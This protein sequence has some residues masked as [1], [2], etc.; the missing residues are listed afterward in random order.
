MAVKPGPFDLN[1]TRLILGPDGRGTSKAVSPT[2]YEDL[3]RDFGDFA[4]HVLI[5]QFEFSE[6]WPTWEVHPEGDEFVYLIRGD[7]DLVLFVEGEEQALRVDP[8]DTRAQG[9]LERARQQLSRMEK[10]SGS[11]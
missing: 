9:Y 8:D 2:F 6:A 4:G 7:T 5:Q 11:Q 1:L 10:I 3:D